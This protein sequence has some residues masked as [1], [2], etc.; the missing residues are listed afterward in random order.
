MT[1]S[2]TPIPSGPRSQKSPVNQSVLGPAA[3][4]R[5]SLTRPAVRSKAL[6]LSSCPWASPITYNESTPTVRWRTKRTI[7]QRPASAGTSHTVY[8][9]VLSAPGGFF[10]QEHAG[11]VHITRVRSHQTDLNGVVWHGAFF[12]IFDDARIETFRRLDYTYARVVDE[13]WQLVIRRVEC[14]YLSPARM[15]DL[16]RVRVTVP[17]FSR[18]TM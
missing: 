16:L 13:G 14:D 17:S 7:C 18:A 10:M 3:H 2:M 15:D 9:F 1:S 6:T 8:V 12:G 5:L 11:N 4:C